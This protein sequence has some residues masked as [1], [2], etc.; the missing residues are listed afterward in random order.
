M[1]TN[2]NTEVNTSK[3]SS[4][5]STRIKQNNLKLEAETN[6]WRLNQEAK[7]REKQLAKDK[8]AEEE[9]KKAE[10][11]KKLNTESHPWLSENLNYDK[12]KEISNKIIDDI[13][14]GVDVY[15]E[16]YLKNNPGVSSSSSIVDNKG[17]TVDANTVK[18]EVGNTSSVAGT[19]GNT[20]SGKNVKPEFSHRYKTDKGVYTVDNKYVDGM[21]ASYKGYAATLKGKTQRDYIEGYTKILNALRAGEIP[22]ASRK[23]YSGKHFWDMLN[24]LTPE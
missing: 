5:L 11:R 24:R 21:E 6:Q 22:I 16:D 4:D 9:A 23:T 3:S 17:A 8:I 20:E 13:N 19:T 15:S 7:K 18:T 1:S 2:S 14:H 10:W 12:R